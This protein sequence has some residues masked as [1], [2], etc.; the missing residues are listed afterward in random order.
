M[1]STGN[2]SSGPPEVVQMGPP[3]PSRRRRWALI[4]VGVL[5]VGSGIGSAVTHDG[6][7]DSEPT[8]KPTR[9]APTSGEPDRFSFAIPV[10]PHL[11]GVTDDWE[12]I[13]RGPGQLVRIELAAGRLTRT[14]VPSIESSGPVSL[15]VEPDRVVVRPLDYVP[16][17][18]VVD[19]DFSSALPPALRHGGLALPG[20]RAGTVWA[21]RSPGSAMRLVQIDG[22]LTGTTV[23]LPADS[24]ATSDGAGYILASTPNA[25]WWARPHRLT[26]ISA[27]SLQAVGP[28]GWMVRECRLGRC[29]SV[30][31]DRR[32]GERSSLPGPALPAGVPVGVIA[33]DGSTAALFHLA[34]SDTAS[35]TL[36]D[37]HSGDRREVDVPVSATSFDSTVAWSPDSRWLF[38]SDAHRGLVVVD[39]ENGD[40]SDLGVSL[41]PIDQLAVRTQ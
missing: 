7:G 40:I 26:R 24:W 41:P 20:P 17:Y 14:S 39:A 1:T 9:T 33:P 4:V 29:Q 8:A 15:I 19:G 11:L 36:L 28:T 34:F 13:G 23:R 30:A 2:G 32:S 38:V 12:L 35:L 25:V 16:G 3:G 6:S 18:Q 5:L 10:G 37:L 21:L 31:I 22:G 27:G